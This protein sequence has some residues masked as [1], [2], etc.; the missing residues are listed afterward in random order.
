MSPLCECGLTQAKHAGG[1]GPAM[2]T[3]NGKRVWCHKFREVTHDPDPD[4]DPV[5]AGRPEP[6]RGDRSDAPSVGDTAACVDCGAYT[7][8]YPS[9]RCWPCIEERIAAEQALGGGEK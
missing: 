2:A 7:I 9:L 4:R 3:L 6:G 8:V 5:P 1:T